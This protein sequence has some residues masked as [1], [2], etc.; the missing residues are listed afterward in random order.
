MNI[1]NEMVGTEGS[2][3][4]KEND[5]R[6]A[7]IVYE[8]NG[9]TILIKHTEVDDA[10]AG[11]GIGQKLVAAVVDQARDSSMRLKSVCSFAKKVLDKTPEYAD[12][13]AR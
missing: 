2:F 5:K 1:Q 10:I 11:K 4:I 9:D 7:E 8:V 3:F 12:V 13:Y 6:L